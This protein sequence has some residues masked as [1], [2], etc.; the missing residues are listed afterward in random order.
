MTQTSDAEYRKA[1]VTVSLILLG[2]KVALRTNDLREDPK[3]LLE[4]AEACIK[5]DAAVDPDDPDFDLKLRQVTRKLDAIKSLKT[6]SNAL[7]EFRW[8]D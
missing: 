2:R 3:A 1:L 4:E 6:L 7:D 8:D 5:E